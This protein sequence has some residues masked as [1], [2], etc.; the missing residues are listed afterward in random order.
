MSVESP[1]QVTDTSGAGVPAAAVLGRWAAELQPGLLPPKVRD[2]SKELLLDLLAVTLRGSLEASSRPVLDLVREMAPRGPSS[3][4]G[5]RM[6]STPAWA[7]MAN[8]T[9]AHAIEMDDVTRESSLHPGVAVIPAALAVAEQRGSSPDE[10]LAGIVAG[11]EVML[12]VGEALNPASTYARGFHPTGVA[13]TYGAAAAAAR[14]LGLSAEES[15]RALGIAGTMAAGSFEYLA[16]GSWSKRLNP[17]WAAHGGVIAAELARRGFTGPM[18]AID[19]RLGTLRGYSD[20]P[21]P[22]RLTRGLGDGYA[23]LGV[24]IKPYACC[25]YNH[26]VIDGV[27]ALRAEH[28][29]LPDE[30]A[31]IRVGMV[32][33]GLG[34]VGDPIDQ[35]RQP[36]SVVD[37][38]FSAPFAAAVALVHGAAGLEQYTREAVA[39]PTIRG[40][41][42]RIDCYSD[43]DLDGRYPASWPVVVQVD[44]TDGT[45]LEIRLE[46]AYG[47]PENPVSQSALVDKFVEFGSPVLG[48]AAREIA[49]RVLA[50]EDEARLGAPFTEMRGG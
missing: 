29:L 20:A 17:G 50:I 11:Y 43:D 34:I 40:L 26:A 36:E 14:V 32:R 4:L 8:G 28:A 33:A 12:R 18:S 1:A 31:A 39:D 22:E 35:K 38:Q 44:R 7:A 10:L 41:M 6:G 49:A 19:G 16:D 27:L 37:A 30:V 13:G 2:R 45:H 21:K 47:D 46:H 15:G 25:R 5:A 23:I 9:S 48:P 24:S 42:A 3:V